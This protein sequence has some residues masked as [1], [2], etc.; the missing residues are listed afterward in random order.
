MVSDSFVNKGVNFVEG[1]PF[2]CTIWEQNH[3]NKDS[4]SLVFLE[5][6][7]PLTTDTNELPMH[8]LWK[9]MQYSRYLGFYY[10]PTQKT[11]RIFAGFWD[12]IS[13]KYDQMTDPVFHDSIYSAFA[14]RLNAM[15]L[16]RLKILD[17]GV[18]TG[19]Y[20]IN[21]IH[22]LPEKKL[23]LYGVDISTQM[24]KIAKQKGVKGKK[25]KQNIIPY[26]SNYFDAV[27]SC[28][29]IH[30]FD[31]FSPFVE[32]HRVLK[33]S[34]IIVFNHRYPQ[35]GYELVYQQNLEKIGF[36][37]VLSEKIQVLTDLKGR[38]AWITVACKK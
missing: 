2:P 38:D 11:E 6:N 5:L 23:D 10:L 8:I 15:P 7:A 14:S 25:I 35:Q 26:P 24:V 20:T 9:G 22:R 30:L 29:V 12:F 18:G 1:I 28:F 32:W 36:T 37:E 31:D 13:S 4:A 34:G 27:I 17:Y 19:A 3:K 21:L 33:E 16:T